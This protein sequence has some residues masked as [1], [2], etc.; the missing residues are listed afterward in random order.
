M[1]ENWKKKRIEQC[2]KVRSGD[3]LPASKMVKEGNIAVYGG[4]GV[5]GNHDQHNL[6]GENIIIGR[7][8]AKCGNVKRSSED[9]WVTD[10]AFYISE[11]LEEFD[12]RF[13]EYLLNTKN[14]RNTANQTAQPVISYTTIKNVILVIP[15]LSEQKRIVSIVDQAFEGID[16]AIAHTKKNRTN[17][18]ELFGSYL[19]TIFTQQGDEWVEKK[20]EDVCESIIDCINK[21]APIINES[22]PFKMIRTTN[23]RNGYVNL[24]SVRYVSEE[25]YRQWTRRQTPKQGDVLLT[26]E[27]PMGEV[28]MLLTDDHVFLGQR[29]VSYRTNPDKLN[30][31]FLLYAF[32]SRDLQDQIKKLASGSTVQHMRVPDT[33]ILRIAM[34]SIATQK[35]IVEKLD[36]LLNQRQGCIPV[37]QVLI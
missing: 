35:Q 13:L 15:P 34:P 16:R 19:N 31:K 29:I 11:L 5:A 4:N 7:V 10:N 25:T 32:Q 14:L 28:G 17:A 23:V 1:K 26:R 22:S 20:L 37:L 27:A 2:F 30:N 21:T 33:K 18:R 8:G 36:T 24:D 12:L 3:F 6:T 9:I